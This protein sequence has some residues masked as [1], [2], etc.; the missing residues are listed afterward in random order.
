MSS[1]VSLRIAPGTRT[2][3]SQ[4]LGLE[5]NLISAH[6]LEQVQSCSFWEAQGPSVLFFFLDKNNLIYA[7]DG[8]HEED[9]WVS[10]Q[11]LYM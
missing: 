5:E 3:E 7:T 2:R 10:T 1:W 6:T 11:V 4:L 9:V 8:V